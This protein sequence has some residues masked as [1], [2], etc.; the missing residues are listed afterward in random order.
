MLSY[1][2]P[3]VVKEWEEVMM[4]EWEMEEEWV[5]ETVEEEWVEEE[6]FATKEHIFHLRYATYNCNTIN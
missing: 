1:L 4:E 2:E 5:E 6:V 3:P